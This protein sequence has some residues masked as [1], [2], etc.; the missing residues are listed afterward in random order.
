MNR[1]GAELA[2][3]HPAQAP[4]VVEQ[5]VVV[6]SRADSERAD[7]FAH[8]RDHD[9]TKRALKLFAG[10]A[11]PVAAGAALAIL[12]YLVFWHRGYYSG[13]YPDSQIGL[14]VVSGQSDAIWSGSRVQ[15]FPARMLN[16]EITT[17]ALRGLSSNLWLVRAM[18]A[19]ATATNG[20]LLGLLI[21]RLSG[22]RVAAVVCGWL[23]VVPFFAAEAT[24]YTDA[25]SYIFG[26]AFDLIFLLAMWGALVDDRRRLQYIAFGTIA[27]FLALECYEETFVAALL[28]PTFWP[29]LAWRKGIGRYLPILGRSGIDLAPSVIVAGLLAL[30]YHTQRV[31]SSL[32]TGRGGLDFSPAA[33]IQRSHEYLDRARWMTVSSDWGRPL[34]QDA[35]SR[36]WSEIHHSLWAFMALMVATLLILVTALTL[37]LAARPQVRRG[38]VAAI[39]LSAGVLWCFASIL[40][41]NA[42]LRNWQLE[43]RLLY[44]PTAAAL[45]ALAAMITAL[46]ALVSW[47]PFQR[48]ILLLGGAAV[49][50]SA[51]TML[52]FSAGYADRSALDSAQLRVFE[53]A[54]HSRD[55]PDGGVLV[56]FATDAVGPPMQHLTVGV[57]EGTYSA[58]PALSAAWHRTNFSV[59][60]MN[61]WVGMT[62]APDPD[63]HRLMVQGV[64]VPLDATLLFTFSR[65][66]LVIIDRVVIRTGA[67]GVADLALP[68]GMALRARGRQSTAIVVEDG[69][70]TFFVTPP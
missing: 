62:F 24:L 27:C 13:D 22:S 66:E 57:F 2:R 63:P 38:W 61:R 46:Q 65:G 68:V 30:T 44:I 23:F 34:V 54:V 55:V 48:S 36:G 58:L 7:E 42:L 60:T 9:S 14:N 10:Y 11:A 59:I 70:A 64:S 32:L 21:L 1:D 12:A 35:L 39:I 41:P 69:Q 6:I 28:V 40:L 31:S 29:L 52:G 47:A 5:S 25:I 18:T 53:N 4:V 26:T 50:A 15:A 45:L 16:T 43:Y 19:L 8:P 33:F 37:P 17:S 56:P 20:L 49:V 51:I 67:E 3:L